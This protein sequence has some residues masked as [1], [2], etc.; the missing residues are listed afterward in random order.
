MFHVVE[1]PDFEK[2]LTG[3]ISEDL[4][5]Q[6]KTQNLEQARETLVQRKRDDTAIRNSVSEFC[7]D[8]QES[9]QQPYVRYDVQVDSGDPVE[10]ILEQAHCGQFDLVVIAKHGHGV[11]H[12]NLMG[13]TVRR[14]LRRCE[15]PVL[16]VQASERKQPC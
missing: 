10:K 12:G 1:P 13:D 9:S 4:W 7:Q 2:Y 8:C 16:V 3:Y 5:N 11:I 15:V 6:I 14:V